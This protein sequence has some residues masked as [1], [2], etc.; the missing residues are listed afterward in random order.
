M[1]NKQ[2]ILITGAT[3]NIGGGAA[4]ALAKRTGDAGT[5]VLAELLR[6]DRWMFVR[7]DAA[8]AL[9]ARCAPAGNAALFEAFAEP[10]HVSLEGDIL[11]TLLAVGVE[12]KRIIH[13]C[14]NNG[15]ETLS[16]RNLGASRCV[17]VDA[18]DAF[19]EHGRELIRIAGAEDT[20]ELIHADAYDLPAE[21]NGR[22]DIVLTT[23]GVLG[24]MPDLKG[25][26]QVA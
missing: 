6:Q 3:G 13:L 18:A 15:S 22:F 16:L 5:R 19:L 24:W 20:V 25:F 21:L 26:F 23:I 11:D 1:M 12:G 7:R 2:T 10:G 14:C 8:G 9:S 4:V 17:G